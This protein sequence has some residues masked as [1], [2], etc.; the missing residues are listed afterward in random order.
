MALHTLTDD[1][2]I[3]WDCHGCGQHRTAHVSHDEVQHPTHDE[4]E[5]VLEGQTIDENGHTHTHLIT[6]PTGKKL[7]SDGIVAL[8]TC[9][10]GTRTFLKVKF[11]SEELHAP[12]M[13]DENGDTTPSYMTAQRHMALVKHMRAVGK[14]ADSLEAAQ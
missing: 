9:D 7:I 11:T 2:H 5:T 14:S 8:P 13:I 12:N 4:M 6:R 10:C 1:G 3:A